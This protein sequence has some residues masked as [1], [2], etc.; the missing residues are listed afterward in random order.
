MRNPRT[1]ILMSSFIRDHGNQGNNTIPVISDR[2]QQDAA[3]N[4]RSQIK[5]N[6]SMVQR[7]II[8]IPDEYLATF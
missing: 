7:E 8:K 4:I 5:K 3:N 2:C 6:E 1:S